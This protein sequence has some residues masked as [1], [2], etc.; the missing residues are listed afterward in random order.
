[1]NEP[2]TALVG[3][4]EHAAFF[5]VGRV[6]TIHQLRWWDF[7]IRLNGRFVFSAPC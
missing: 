7:G 3:F 6:L 2:P 5:L 1:M 4:Q